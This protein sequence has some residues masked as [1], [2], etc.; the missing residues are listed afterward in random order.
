[1]NKK[2]KDLKQGDK[3]IDMGYWYTVEDIER[4]DLEFGSPIY[5][6][7]YKGF[8]EG[9]TYQRKES[10]ESVVTIKN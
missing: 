5:L 10:G 8:G 9:K 7:T 4:Q 1:M 3:V 6:I 2:V